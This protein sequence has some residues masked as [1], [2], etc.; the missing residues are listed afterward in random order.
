[1]KLP[2]YLE[3]AL[4]SEEVQIL[5]AVNFGLHDEYAIHLLTGIPQPC[6]ARKINAMVDLGLVEKT[7]SGYIIPENEAEILS[8]FEE[9]A[10]S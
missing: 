10:I 7:E 6:I 1:M 2:K 4:G 5:K 8:H 9:G 3:S